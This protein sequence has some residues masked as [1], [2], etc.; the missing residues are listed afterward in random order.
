M[1]GQ[2]GSGK[3]HTMLGPP[4]T[5]DFNGVI[6][7]SLSDIFER[8]T[9]KEQGEEFQINCSYVEIYNEAIHDLLSKPEDMNTGL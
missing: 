2:T 9:N 1:Y 3:T 6:F 5:Y 8:V 7:Q 4:K